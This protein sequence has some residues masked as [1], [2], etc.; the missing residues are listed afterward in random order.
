LTTSLS[1]KVLNLLQR[2]AGS[3]LEEADALALSWKAQN[4]RNW[5]DQLAALRANASS[6][7]V[8]SAS[9]GVTAQPRDSATDAGGSGLVRVGSRLSA[10][11]QHAASLITA[12]V[13][14]DL[15]MGDAVRAIESMCIC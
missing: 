10:S 1:R 7:S 5:S 14:S 4:A 3:L 15:L 9:D 2:A 12:Q 6:R 13:R 8:G 11:P